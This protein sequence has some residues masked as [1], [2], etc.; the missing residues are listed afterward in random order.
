MT[1]ELQYGIL[2][3]QGDDI[4]SAREEYKLV[5]EKKIEELLIS[6]P[7][8]MR[9]FDLML[10]EKEE[11]GFRTRLQYIRCVAEFINYFSQ[12]KRL[13]KLNTLN[14]LKAITLFDVLNWKKSLEYT[15]KKGKVYP[16]SASTIA[17]KVSAVRKFFNCF[18]DKLGGNPVSNVKRPK[19]R[20]KEPVV[21][22]DGEMNIL[23]S[24]VEDGVGSSRARNY[25]KNY[26]TRDM[27]IIYILSC[28]GIRITPLVGLNL[29]DINL[30]ERTIKVTS[31][32]NITSI[33]NLND[34]V[35][36]WLEKYYKERVEKNVNTNALF[37]S[38]Q[39]SR[40]GA[41]TVRAMITK[42]SAGINK[43]VSPHVFRKTFGTRVYQ[44]KGDIRL[45]AD[46]LDHSNIQVTSQNY[47]LSE[48]EKR[49][50][51]V[52]NIQFINSR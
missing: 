28:T 50:E 24:N 36:Y 51:V 41:R 32:G 10:A 13:Y 15:S 20:A 39:N 12:E 25:Q 16:A 52:N 27:T 23:L 37:I 22:E 26:Y 42:Y 7:E 29:E 18:E 19:V 38:N 44:E 8:Y 14:D 35:F 40:L 1:N 47:V 11:V 21:L 2:I 31:K 5:A 9:K 46:L 48:Q 30:K 34:E 45:V 17:T 4:M 33:K 3:K 6:L 49:K 43:S